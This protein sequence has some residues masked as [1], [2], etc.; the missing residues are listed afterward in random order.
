MSVFRWLSRGMVPAARYLNACPN[1]CGKALG[2]NWN[3]NDQS[4]L[5]QRL[6]KDLDK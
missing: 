5:P 1:P 3:I 2:K 6:G 4:D